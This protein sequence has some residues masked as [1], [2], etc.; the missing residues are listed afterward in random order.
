MSSATATPSV[1]GFSEAAFAAS[2]KSRDEPAWLVDRRKRAFEL[3]RSLAWP[4]AR[5]EEWRR[6]DIRAFR[7][8]QFAPPPADGAPSADDRAAL[9]PTWEGLS[10]SYAI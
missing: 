5:D 3:S 9:A 7:L 2:L 4:S 6:T 10:A 1:S 8:D